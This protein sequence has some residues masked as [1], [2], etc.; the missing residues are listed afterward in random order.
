MTKYENREEHTINQIEKTMINLDNELD[1]I[2]DL[3]SSD[4]VSS[5]KEWREEKKA[6]HEIKRILREVNRYDR[7][8]KKEADDEMY[9]KELDKITG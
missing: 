5:R 7:Y 4:N 8:E 2:N 3:E 9:D 6:L 1:K